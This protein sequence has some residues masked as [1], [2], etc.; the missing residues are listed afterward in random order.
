VTHNMR[1]LH[2]GLNCTP[3][4]VLPHNHHHLAQSATMNAVHPTQQA[5]MLPATRASY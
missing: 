1:L 2:Y 4:T 5:R 3:G